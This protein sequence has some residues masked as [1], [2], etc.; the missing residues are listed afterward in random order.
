[1][2]NIKIYFLE[3]TELAEF[4]AISKGYRN[5]VIVAVSG[6]FYHV[7]VYDIVRLQQD[8]ASELENYGYYSIEPSLVLVK[9][10]SK[11]IIQLTLRALYE[12]N[13]FDHLKPIDKSSIG[14]HLTKY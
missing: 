10:A 14:N 7:Y 2:N 8:F 11:E 4:E 3:D 1:M 9:E 12:Q 5:D 13:Y 6:V